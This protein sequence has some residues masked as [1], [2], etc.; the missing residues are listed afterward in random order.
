M[1]WLRETVAELIGGPVGDDASLKAAGLDSLS[2]ITL[3]QR[4]GACCGRPI[5]VESLQAGDSVSALL[6]SVASFARTGPDEARAA[7]ATAEAEEAVKAAAE[8]AEARPRVLCLH[9]WR[10][11]RDILGV[12]L[13]PYLAR[14]R[15]AFDFVFVDAPRAAT[16]EPEDGI[17]PEVR[18]SPYI[19]PYLA[20]SPHI[21]PYLP[22]FPRGRHPARGAG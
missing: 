22:I 12:Q 11:N 8:V 18:L 16:G 14:H 5:S 15:T 9:G 20:V 13:A 1:A 4:L 6:A 7:A 10:S 19:S 2:L 3:A 21:S 17:P